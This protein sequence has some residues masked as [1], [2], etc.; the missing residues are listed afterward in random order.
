VEQLK[1]FGHHPEGL[2]SGKNMSF[3]KEIRRGSSFELMFKCDMCHKVEK[4]FF[5]PK[6]ESYIWMSTQLL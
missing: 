1:T 3:Q 4:R 6:D 5:E 2:C